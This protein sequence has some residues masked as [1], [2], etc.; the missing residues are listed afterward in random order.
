MFHLQRGSLLVS[1]NVQMRDGYPADLSFRMDQLDLDSF[2]HAYLGAQLSG[3]SAVAGS[4]DLHGPLFNPSRWIVN[5]D[6]SAVS[7]DIENVKLHNQDPVRLVL[8]NQ[9]IDIRQLHMLGEG[10]D[11]TAHGSMQLSG[12]RPLDLAADG[13]L[14][15]KLL[16]SFDPDLTASGLVT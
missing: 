10:T 11:L 2:W 4:L 12:A 16:S 8:A 5:G 13:R 3:H 6:L 9:S 14:D 1:G 7:L 15:L